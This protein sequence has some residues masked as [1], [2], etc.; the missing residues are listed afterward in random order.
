MGRKSR[1]NL[2]N[3]VNQNIHDNTQ[4]EI[5]ASMVREVLREYR[6]SHFNWISDELKK[7]KYNATQTLEEYLNTIAGSVPLYGVI[8]GVNV[9]L[10]SGNIDIRDPQGNP[11][12]DI[13][14]SAKYLSGNN[15]YDSLIEINF[16]VNLANKR[17]IPVITTSSTDFDNQNDT[18][19]PVIR[20]IAPKR[21]HMYLRKIAPVTQSLDI[22][23]IAI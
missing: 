17:L 21:I 8:T 11:Q 13:I 12:S 23:I 14:Q 3:L 5:L 4:K 6:D 7:A 10:S 16:S 2:T 22:E 1:E 9:G 15:T 18:C 20:R 19:S